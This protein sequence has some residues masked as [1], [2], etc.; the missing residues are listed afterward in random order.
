MSGRRR[1][2]PIDS[3]LPDTGY[4]YIQ[5]KES[6]KEEKDP[7][8]KKVKTFTEKP[9]LEMAQSFLQSGDFL[10]NAGI[11]VWSVKSIVKAY[12]KFLPDMAAAFS[13][14]KY[15]S[16]KEEELGDSKFTANERR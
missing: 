6:P 9:D 10:W 13:A 14:V 2:A 15:N 4:G 3:R 1:I 8:I 16:P 12:Q 11:F 7:R 5:F